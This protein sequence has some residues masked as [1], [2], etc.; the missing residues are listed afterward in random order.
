MQKTSRQIDE[1]GRSL[2][3]LNK[4][5]RNGTVLTDKQ[6]EHMA[7]LAAKMERLNATRDQEMVK[8]RA[9]AQALRG[10]GVSLAGSTATIQS[11]I[12]RTEQYNQTLER[13]R[14]QLAAVTQARARYDRMQQIAGKLRN[15]GT[16]AIATATAGMYASTRVLAPQVQAE[17]SGAV[18]AAQSG[19]NAAAGGRYTHLIQDLNSSGVSHNLEMASEALSIVRSALGYL[20]DVGD[21]ELSRITR[22]TLDMQKVFK[23]DLAEGIQTAAILMKNKLV[24]S[25]DEAF[26]LMTTGMKKMS[27]SMRG[28]LPEILHEYSTHFRNMGFTGREAMSLLVGMSQQGKF[29]LDKTGDAIKEFSIRG[30][31]MSKKSV[32][33]YKQ[34]GLSAD[35]MSS[36]I[37]RGGAPARTAMQKTA[38]GLLAI[39]D[40][41]E[42]AN[43]AIRLFGTPIEDLSVDQ[44]PAFLLAFANTS[45][46]LGDVRG[47][48]DQM[49]DTL[50]E[51]PVR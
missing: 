42:R 29:A 1:A 31:D 20:G 27:A 41:A 32:E 24:I 10:H 46:R 15:S 40:P 12:R 11:A 4:A 14:L 44:I 50:R 3:G 16:V 6:R 36:A 49:G 8:L 21:N 51:Q 48:A 35:T 7:A 26:D 39:R 45:D 33:A 23:T 30:S 22:K 47:K 13:E 25:S 2:E 19:E 28:E 38:R 43:A 34:I 18:I 9:S 17:G 5:Q 37:A